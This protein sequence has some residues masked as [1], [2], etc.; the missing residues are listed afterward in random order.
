LI[1][2]PGSRSS[3]VGLP[4]SLSPA[5][6]VHVAAYDPQA[7]PN[8]SKKRSAGVRLVAW[9]LAG[10]VLALLADWISSL[11][12][13]SAVLGVM[14]SSALAVLVVGAALVAW[15]EMAAIRRLRDASETRRIIS[16]A[17]R[18]PDDAARILIPVAQQLGEQLAV[19]DAADRWLRGLRSQ[20]SA[21]EV[22]ESFERE[23]LGAA[24]ALAIQ[25]TARSARASGALTMLSPSPV[26]DF[27]L[28]G[29]RSVCLLREIATIYGL[30]PGRI[31]ELA[32]LRRVV[33]D[34]AMLSAADLAT[35]VAS[36]A[37]GRVTG[38]VLGTAAQ[39]GLA[40]YRMSRFGLL[41][42]GVCR[43]LPFSQATV[44]TVADVMKNA[45]NGEGGGRP[46]TKHE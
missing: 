25:A 37:M 4:P 35:D 32:M 5:A 20:R 2:E 14:A 10:L 43:P 6:P 13:N 12:S 41:A 18:N 42:I 39:G 26:G 11:Y 29:W 9:G 27:L 34:G 40:A 19:A 44:P 45:W 7:A 31:A 16:G 33:A 28:F 24:D 1:D 21:D 15:R 30:R 36:S 23:V 8:R 22:R 46:E 38:I 3:F 17:H